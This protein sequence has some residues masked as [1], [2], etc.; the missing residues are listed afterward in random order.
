M[1]PICLASFLCLLSSRSVNKPPHIY[2]TILVE[3]GTEADVYTRRMYLQTFY[4]TY[5]DVGGQGDLVNQTLAA[6][7]MNVNDT[8]LQ[9]TESGIFGCLCSKGIY[10]YICKYD[11]YVYICYSILFVYIHPAH[12]KTHDTIAAVFSLLGLGEASLQAT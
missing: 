3:T 6:M 9:V 8:G 7:Q 1:V 10:V 12:T 11:W 2:N 4:H 5:V